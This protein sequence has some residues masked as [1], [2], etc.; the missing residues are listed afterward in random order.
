MPL[1]EYDLVLLEEHSA[2]RLSLRSFYYLLWASMCARCYL[3]DS[4]IHSH[5]ADTS[6]TE[7]P[8]RVD[9]P[10]RLCDQPVLVQLHKRDPLPDQGRHVEAGTAQGAFCLFFFFFFFLI[11]VLF[12]LCL[13]HMVE[14][15]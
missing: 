1:S 5:P 6:L 9:L 7:P 2:V 14:I 3:P 12:P 4:P 11:R 8:A 13:G 10:L 15:S